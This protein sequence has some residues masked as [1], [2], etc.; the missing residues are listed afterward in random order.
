MRVPTTAVCVFDLD[1]TLVSSPLD[2]RAVGRE[3]E[4]LI[5]ARGL[6]VPAELGAKRRTVGAS[7]PASALRIAR[8]R[9]ATATIWA[10]CQDS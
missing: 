4:A 1:H 6:S 3:M 2:L 10:K 7:G 9:H 5:R 8:S